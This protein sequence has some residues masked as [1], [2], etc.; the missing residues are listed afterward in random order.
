[1]SSGEEADPKPPLVV[2]TR[3]GILRIRVTHKESTG[4]AALIIEVPRRS[5]ALVSLQLTK[6]EKESLISRLKNE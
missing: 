1:M 5:R 6:E 3:K 4:E 2:N